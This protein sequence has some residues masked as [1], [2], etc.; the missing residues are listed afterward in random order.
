MASTESGSR[1]RKESTSGNQPPPI[2]QFHCWLN[3]LPIWTN[4]QGYQLSRIP[5]FYV[6][7]R[8]TPR[9]TQP[10]YGVPRFI[11]CHTSKI[12]TN[13]LSYVVLGE[14]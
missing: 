9:D 1:A 8:L 6:R 10:E 11:P 5:R 2:T 3:T 4:R 7:G 12:P 13:G 14:R